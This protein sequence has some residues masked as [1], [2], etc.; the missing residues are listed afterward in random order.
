MVY[1]SD[2][3]LAIVGA[4]QIRPGPFVEDLALVCRLEVEVL[5]VLWDELWS[6]GS[7]E[8]RHVVVMSVVSRATRLVV[9]GLLRIDKKKN[10]GLQG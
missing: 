7:E 3:R 9:K 8:S 10:F 6:P 4:V 2:G 5:R 1:Q